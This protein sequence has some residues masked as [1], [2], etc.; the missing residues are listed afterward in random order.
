M[1]PTSTGLAIAGLIIFFMLAVVS[2]I[3]ARY[4]TFTNREFVLLFRNG[5]LIKQGYGG[6]HFILPFIDEIIVLSTTVQTKEIKA[7]EIITAENQDVLIQG[8]VVWRIED[9]VKAYQSISG[10]QNRGVMEEINKTLTQLVESIIRTTVARLTIDQVLRER[11]LIIEAILEELYPVVEPLGIVISTAEIKHIEVVDQELFHDLQERYRQ[12]ARLQ[13]A[14]VKIQT[15]REIQKSKAESQQEVR[16]YQ[17]EQEEKAMIR[18]LEKEK[19]IIE[20][21]QQV[22]ISEEEKLL[23]VQEKEKKRESNVAKLE[24]ERAKI[25]AETELMQV[26]FEAQSKKRREILEKI[27]VEAEKEKIMAQVEAEKKKTLAEAEAAAIRAEAKARKDAI[28]MAAAAEA[29]RLEILAEATK[30]NLLAEAEGKKAVLLAEAEGMKEKVRAQ[31]YVNEA[32][33]MQEL[34]RQLPA[35]ASSM[36]VGDINWLNMAGGNG[37]NSD[38]PLGIIPKNLLQIMSLAK[39]FGLDLEQLI[40]TIRGQS[41]NGS[42]NHGDLDN[43]GDYE[44][45]EA[46]LVVPGDES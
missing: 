11:S 7:T 3:K 2:L 23:A 8:F 41:A 34:I 22:Q 46:L 40:S 1:N 37:K 38:S 32:M 25:A 19:K 18:E 33:I 10:V 27:E 30:K 36:K 43:S 39:S 20:Q 4:K 6:A 15:D 13:A 44:E 31:G 26:D 16:L 12:E 35:I 14:Q 28:E 17:A 5:K 29:H 45:D 42:A 24:M 9:P 21:Q